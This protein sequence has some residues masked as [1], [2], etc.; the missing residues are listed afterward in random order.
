M[1]EY[2]HFWET[3]AGDWVRSS[4]HGVAAVVFQYFSADPNGKS[5]VL[6]QCKAVLSAMFAANSIWEAGEAVRLTKLAEE[7]SS[8]AGLETELEGG[9]RGRAGPVRT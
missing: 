9:Y 5:G 1:P 4:L 3:A 8:M 2:S 6:L 7:Y